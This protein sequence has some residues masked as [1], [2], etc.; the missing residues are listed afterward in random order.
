MTIQVEPI[1]RDGWTPLPIEGCR[2]VAVKM[3]MKS[4][5]L[6]LAM[7]RF[8]LDGTIHEH[9]ADIEIDVICLEGEGMVSV[10]NEQSPLKSGE[11]VRLPKGIPH[12]LWTNA[13]QMCTL[14][15]EY[16]GVEAD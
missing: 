9:P 8:D 3:L 5:R 14:M 13:T 2:N 12:R 4:H 6:G 7:L 16:H 15:V 10:G 11:R 1:Q